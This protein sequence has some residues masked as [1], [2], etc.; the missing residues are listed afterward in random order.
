MRD[1]VTWPDLEAALQAL[2]G[3]RRVGREY[4]GP[5]PVT[6][7]G[8]DCCFAS[9]GRT[10]VALG[11]R[12]C[13]GRLT[14]ES[15]THHLAALAGETAREVAPHATHARPATS[16]P[17]DLSAR[18]WRASAA[19]DG[20]PGARY[21]EQRGVWPAG[22]R[23]PA[24]VRWL[25]GDVARRVGVGREYHGPCPVTGA[26][27][28][29][30]SAPGGRAWRS[31]AGSA[32]GGSRESFTHHLAALAGET[33]REVAPHATHARPATSPSS[34]RLWPCGARD[35]R[36][37]LGQRGVWPAGDRLPASVRWLP[38]DVAR[39]VGVTPRLPRGAAG[40][41]VYRS[42][43]RIS[44]PRGRKTEPP[45]PAATRRQPPASRPF[46]QSAKRLTLR[47][48]LG[49][50][51]RPFANTRPSLT[52]LPLARHCSTMRRGTVRP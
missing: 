23:L 41:V 15:F 33:A 13:G 11:C 42:P 38:G 3:W 18:L 52:R 21:L 30:A 5:C 16:P 7:A 32:A 1:R 25:P 14:R 20:T 39:R 19:P 2:D 47:R 46:R 40:C 28:I 4:H 45:A 26:G 36:R 35:T 8:R 12:Q 51:S 6:G 49:C 27:V 31:A 37:A 43:G 44:Q 29:V 10:G 50:P 24:S 9:A 48:A 22:D 34:A 17:S